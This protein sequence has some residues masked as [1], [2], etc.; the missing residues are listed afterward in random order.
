MVTSRH[1]HPGR[2]G[3]RSPSAGGVSR[4]RFLAGTAGAGAL[5]VSAGTIAASP[6]L[7]STRGGQ[8]AGLPT[9]QEVWGWQE[10]LVRFGTRYTGSPGHAAYVDW[11]TS[12]LTAVPVS[13]CRPTG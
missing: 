13:P 9:I 8:A 7:A 6:S 1:D 5:A 12:H 3:G 10:Q 2:S 11:L 4:R